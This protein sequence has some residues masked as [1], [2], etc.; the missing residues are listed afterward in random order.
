MTVMDVY[1]FIDSIAP[2]AT[3]AEFDNSGLTIGDP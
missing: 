1:R 3:Q 2:Y